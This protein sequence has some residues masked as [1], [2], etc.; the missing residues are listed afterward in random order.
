M[1]SVGV[2]GRPPSG[3]R[4]AQWTPSDFKAAAGVLLGA[5]P[6]DKTAELPVRGLR[7]APSTGWGTLPVA[8]TARVQARPASLDASAA[9]LPQNRTLRTSR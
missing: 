5:D 4:R 2:M 1:Q 7:V 8:G 6:T 3:V 9:A